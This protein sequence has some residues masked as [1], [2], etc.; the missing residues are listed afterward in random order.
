[1]I[2]VWRRV[3]AT[4]AGHALG[5]G[6]EDDGTKPSMQTATSITCSIEAWTFY[7][8]TYI[9]KSTVQ[10]CKGSVKLALDR[11]SVRLPLLLG[12][13]HGITFKSCLVPVLR[14]H[15]AK[16]EGNIILKDLIGTARVWTQAMR[17]FAR[18]IRGKKKRFSSVAESRMVG[19]CRHGGLNTSFIEDCA[20][21]PKEKSTQ[22]GRKIEAHR[23][24]RPME[25]LSSS[26]NSESISV[27]R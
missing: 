21:W 8:V 19:R 16:T 24:G 9:Y 6:A 13:P 15:T 2:S 7:S 5:F 25:P 20:G 22:A 18:R 27:R 23:S 1:M 10:C 17:V 14:Y 11:K 3:L 26:P 12:N 4:R